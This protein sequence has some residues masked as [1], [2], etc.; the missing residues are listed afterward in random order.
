[1]DTLDLYASRS[2]SE[3]GKR[4]AKVVGIEA[5]IVES[6]LLALLV[7]AEKAT[8]QDAAEVEAPAAMSEAEREEAR[9]FLLRRDLLDQVVRD[10][11]ALGF[12][13]EEANIKLLFLIANSRRSGQPLSALIL[14]PSGAGKSGITEVIEQLTP[15]EDVV[16]F[17]RL[18]PQSLY[19]TEPGYLDKKLV[20]IEERHG[21]QEA[22]YSVR[23]LQSR[24][25]LIAAAPV[26]DPQTGNL[27]TKVFT[28][29]A[30]C[31][32][33]EATT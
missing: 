18:T 28:V 7:E 15:P 22:D 3:F 17:T 12:V 5:S 29:E 26:K 2:R 10:A 27:R 1:M 20:I 8:D 21:S 14:S 24:G 4:A 6:A 11:W 9:G 30:R 25:K 31:A 23:V 16:L 19:Y 32:F 33:I 13:G